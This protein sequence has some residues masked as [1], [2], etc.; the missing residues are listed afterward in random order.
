M[1][2]Y[3]VRKSGS[4]SNAG[5]SAGA[6]W[7]TIAKALSSSGIASGDTVYV[8]AGTYREVV[9][10]AM[11]SATAETK[12][13]GDVS[14]QYTGDPGEVIWTA[15]V[16]DD[17]T[18]PVSASTLDL[19][20]R[21][22]L[23]FENLVIFAGTSRCVAGS[24]THSTNIT[25]RRCSLRASVTGNGLATYTGVVNVAGNWLFENCYLIAH[26]SG[27]VIVTLP[28]SSSADYDASIVFH[29]CFFLSLGTGGN[30]AIQL[31][32]TG[33]N[34]FKGGGVYVYNC[35]FWGINGISAAN[36]TT[37]YP[38][39]VYNSYFY[40]QGTALS[41]A[42]T[43]LLVEDYNV[44]TAGTSRTNVSTGSNSATNTKAPAWSEG[45]EHLLGLRQVRPWGM[46]S[47]SSVLLGF[48]A[49]SGGPS[50]D[51]SGGP[52]PS[53]GGSTSYAVGP[54]ERP[55]SGTKETSVTHAGSAALK[56]TG[57]GYHDFQVPVDASATTITIYARYDTNHA[58]TN[59]PQIKVLNGG[60]CGVAD[61]TATMTAAVD[62]WEALALTFTPTSAGIVTIR[63]ISRSAAGNG[64]AYFDS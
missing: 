18:A 48:G 9:T 32:S 34:S 11:T 60:E 41:A 33:A 15:R 63:C 2:T 64:I 19:A 54:F 37:T 44:F 17:N 7:L 43:G 51:M 59:K 3:Y 16:T 21:D 39:S 42:S 4:D 22:Y 10:V 56:I 1:A 14:G 50:T 6:A 52:R 35:S 12:I 47:E 13:I 36:G 55:H 30:W 23:T 26:S 25:F 8:G 58:A 61:D 53:G 5:T 29:N 40:M 46:P 45:R 38:L 31:G 28:T 24:T 57:P 49:Q 62:T 27:G 20:G